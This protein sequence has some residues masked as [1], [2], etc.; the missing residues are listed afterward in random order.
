MNKF[1]LWMGALGMVAALGACGG[2]GS[3]GSGVA[4]SPTPAAGGPSGPCAGKSV[5]F[6]AAASVTD[7]FKNGDVVCFTTVSSTTLA[8]NGKTL[9]SPTQ[10]TAVSAPFSAWKFADGIYTYE[11]IFNGSNPHEINVSKNSTFVGQFDFG[12][13]PV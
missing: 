4:P 8:F 10:N 2:G 1:V 7:P 12:S 11:V 3:G 5:S 6:A 13:A 9:S